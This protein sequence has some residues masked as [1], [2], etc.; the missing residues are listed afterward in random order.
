M[1]TVYKTVTDL[2]KGITNL[3]TGCRV[4]LLFP[5]FRYTIKGYVV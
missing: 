4:L 5:F 2:Y 1:E 3:K